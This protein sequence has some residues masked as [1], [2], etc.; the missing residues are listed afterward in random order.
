MKKIFLIS[1]I[2][3]VSSCAV[4]KKKLSD[5]GKKVKVTYTEPKK[6]CDALVTVVGENDEGMLPL[7]I[8]HARNLV[9]KEDGNLLYIKDKVNNSKKWRVHG[10]GYSCSK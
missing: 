3:M 4:S 6:N 7:A 9:A 1:M 10:V 5:D 8:N 2:L